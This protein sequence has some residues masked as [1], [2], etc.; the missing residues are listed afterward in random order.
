[1]NLQTCTTKA[2]AVIAMM[3]ALALVA[4]PAH[5]Q[6]ACPDPEGC[7]T[8]PGFTIL[9]VDDSVSIAAG[10]TVEFDV[11]ANDIGLAEE[12][13]IVSG[14]SAPQ[15]GT[16]ASLIVGRFAY[17]PRAGFSGTDGFAYT[18]SGSGD[19]DTA[20]VTITVAPAPIL[21]PAPVPTSCSS[22]SIAAVARGNLRPAQAMIRLRRGA[23]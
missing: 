3:L 6:E 7:A 20:A 23:R 16:R 15:S 11:L 9:A 10:Q 21:A 1:M 8:S 19:T 22:R 13:L 12:P 14:Y 17:T 5:A 2:L 18:I 4:S